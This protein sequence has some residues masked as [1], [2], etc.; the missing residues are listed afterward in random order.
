ML[1]DW[2][3]AYDIYRLKFNK[4]KS[5]RATLGD[6]YQEAWDSWPE[7][8]WKSDNDSVVLVQTD[9]RKEKQQRT[10]GI[11]KCVWNNV[12][13]LV[14]NPPAVE[15][16][17]IA[18]KEEEL[19]GTTEP[20]RKPEFFTGDIPPNAIVELPA[21]NRPDQSAFTEAVNVPPPGY[22][23]EPG[24]KRVMPDKAPFAFEWPTNKGWNAQTRLGQRIRL[25]QNKD[26]KIWTTQPGVAAK[27]VDTELKKLSAVKW[28]KKGAEDIYTR[29]A[30]KTLGKLSEREGIIFRWMCFHIYLGGTSSS[31][32]CSTDV[33]GYF[34][35]ATSTQCEF[36]YEQMKGPGITGLYASCGYTKY[37]KELDAHM[38]EHMSRVTDMDPLLMESYA[39]CAN[40]RGAISTRLVWVVAQMMNAYQV[41][42]IDFCS[43]L[44]LSER[45]WEVWCQQWH[46]YKRDYAIGI[47]H[48]INPKSDQRYEL[49]CL[50]IETITRME[51]QEQPPG[52][53]DA[54]SWVT[55]NPAKCTFCTQTYRRY[56]NVANAASA[57]WN[58]VVNC[59]ETNL[60]IKGDGPI[61]P[62]GNMEIMDYMSVIEAKMTKCGGLDFETNIEWLLTSLVETALSTRLEFFKTLLSSHSL[63]AKKDQ[64]EQ[65]GVNIPFLKLIANGQ[66]FNPNFFHPRNNL[67][68]SNEESKQC[69]ELLQRWIQVSDK[70]TPWGGLTIVRDNEALPGR[71]FSLGS[72]EKM[73]R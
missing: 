39:W 63:S 12:R 22:E 41:H 51:I 46:M 40:R 2:V 53:K 62:E 47:T 7:K 55:F 24:A 18:V 68:Q 35:S 9:I 52:K 50:Y 15:T 33:F 57:A 43:L 21:F 26:P 1:G 56:E 64:E 23:D 59:A 71:G 61:F 3:V 70:V 48:G 28:T 10:Q 54:Q 29:I 27:S 42:H 16:A 67:I 60:Q 45:E 69:H 20:V 30:E 72:S 73:E 17:A 36:M 5:M 6:T 13:A 14:G 66:I 65:F 44:A 8:V 31:N 37:V 32:P 11:M 38:D 34:Q 4:G 58:H 19:E 25:E 49:V